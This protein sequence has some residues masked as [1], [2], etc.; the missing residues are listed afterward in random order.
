M[1]DGQLKAPDSLLN[2]LSLKS[3]DLPQLRQFFCDMYAAHVDILVAINFRHG[4]QP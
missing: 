3:T 2:T 1:G 4:V